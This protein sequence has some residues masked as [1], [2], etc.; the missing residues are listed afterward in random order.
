MKPINR[1]ANVQMYMKKLFK[2]WPNTRHHLEHREDIDRMLEVLSELL[3]TLVELQETFTECIETL[4]RRQ[5]HRLQEPMDL[6]LSATLLRNIVKE[7]CQ[8][9]KKSDGYVR[10]RPSMQ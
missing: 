2:K 8:E 4:E 6:P 3:Q 5:Q 1:T 10:L 7:R 9:E